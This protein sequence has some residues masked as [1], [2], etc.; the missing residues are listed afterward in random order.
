MSDLCICG[1]KQMR[2]ILPRFDQAGPITSSTYLLSNFTNFLH[3]GRGNLHN[4]LSGRPV[5]CSCRNRTFWVRLQQRIIKH[6]ISCIV[7]IIGRPVVVSTCRASTVLSSFLRLPSVAAGA[8]VPK[9]KT[10]EYT[11]DEC[12]TLKYSEGDYETF[13]MD[14][15]VAANAR[16]AAVAE[17][18]RR[19]QSAAEV[20]PALALAT[21]GTEHN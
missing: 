16:T 17:V 15:F 20:E 18:V 5:F 11:I 7:F 9:G 8:V 19:V 3:A 12:C 13:E 10:L 4:D 6:K 2:A 21:E 14:S 1:W